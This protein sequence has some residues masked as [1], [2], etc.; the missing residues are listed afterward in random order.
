MKLITLGCSYTKDF[1]QKTWADYL[2][3]KLSY[4]LIN[5]A[6]RGAGLDFVV[7]RLLHFN[8]DVKNSTVVIMLPSADRFDWYVDKGSP[9]QLEALKIASWQNGKEPNLVSLDGEINKDHGFCL[10][11]G[12]YRGIK[13]YWFKYFYTELKAELDFWNNVLFLQLYLNNVGV[14]YF[15]T[16]AHNLDQLVEEENNLGKSKVSCNNIISKI[17]K[18]KFILGENNIGFLDFCKKNKFEFIETH[19]V[20]AAHKKFVEEIMIKILVELQKK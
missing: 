19:P 14:P 17:D 10:S 3:E 9:L 8:L 13:K 11:G 20:E 6:Q 18:N 16:S 1:Y 7:K 2:A 5:L 15:F 4:E 12:N